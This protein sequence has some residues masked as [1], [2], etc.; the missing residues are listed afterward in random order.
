MHAPGSM[1]QVTGRGFDG[2]IMQE[3]RRKKLFHRKAPV[4]IAIN[5]VKTE[6]FSNISGDLSG[7]LL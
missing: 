3:L 4:F 1:A 7:E 2:K 5:A 6:T